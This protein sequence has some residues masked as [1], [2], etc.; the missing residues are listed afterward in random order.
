MK[1]LE[2]FSHD[3]FGGLILASDFNTTYE[4]TKN[5]AERIERDWQFDRY[6][7]QNLNKP[8]NRI[9]YETTEKKYIWNRW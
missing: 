8:H 4:G 5:I 6:C 1:T 3:T 9:N 2:K 7:E